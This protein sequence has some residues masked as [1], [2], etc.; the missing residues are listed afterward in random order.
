MV[1]RT[2]KLS[3]NPGGEGSTG[4]GDRVESSPL[5]KASIVPLAP[6][7]QAVS[8]GVPR[9]AT[10]RPDS[11]PDPSGRDG[12]P[13]PAAAEAT[14]GSPAT[15]AVPPPGGE[16]LLGGPQVAQ[17]GA[18]A[19]PA[20]AVHVCPVGEASENSGSE[21]EHPEM[22]EENQAI[23]VDPQILARRRFQ[24]AVTPPVAR[25]FPPSKAKVGPPERTPFVVSNRGVQRQRD[26]PS[27]FSETWDKEYEPSAY[28]S[29]AWKTFVPEK[30]NGHAGTSSTRTN[31]FTKIRCVCRRTWFGVCCK[32]TML[33]TVTKVLTGQGRTS[34]PDTFSLSQLSSE[35]K[36]KGCVSCAW[37]A[38]PAKPRIGSEP[39]PLK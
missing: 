19:H 14:A 6:P 29:E 20:A 17:P 23:E 21:E 15:T 7:P 10:G 33:G 18:G 38:R 27:V 34:Y 36:W 31:Y 24:F 26:K 37:S 1:T 30:M 4:H 22:E 25:P 16:G 8:G 39:N 11:G 35:L 32:N 5:S 3:Q 12:R 2:G 28:F 13:G 9:R